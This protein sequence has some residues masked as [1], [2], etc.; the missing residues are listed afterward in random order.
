VRSATAVP[1]SWALP[2]QKLGLAGDVFDLEIAAAGAE[3]TLTKLGT[4]S[5]RLL[6]L[7]KRQTPG[8]IDRG[9]R[10]L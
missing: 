1:G 2:D 6:A 7:G 9:K 4:V 5:G 8:H 3:R 10:S